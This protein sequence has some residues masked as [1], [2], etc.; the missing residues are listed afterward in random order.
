[1]SSSIASGIATSFHAG[2]I[3]KSAYDPR[4]KLPEWIAILDKAGAKSWPHAEIALWLH[5]KHKV[6]DWWCQMVTV[7]YEQASGRRVKNQKSDG[8]EISVSKTIAAPV[9]VAFDAWKD[10]A[11]REQW[12]PGVQLTVRKATPHKS[13]RITWS[14][15]TN[16]SVNFWPKGPLK[17]QVVPQHAKLADAETAEKMKTYWAD[18][19]EALR[20]FLE[21][22]P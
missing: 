6:P 17:C 7:G 12:L 3:A 19:L 1:M 9:A 4:L 14:D 22:K 2:T 18:Q 5:K 15:G 11:L 13:I 8:F 20:A 16:L 21:K 10:A